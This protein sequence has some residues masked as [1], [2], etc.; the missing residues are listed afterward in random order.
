[1]TCRVAFEYPGASGGVEPLAGWNPNK[2]RQDTRA[3][4]MVALPVNLIMGE[5]THPYFERNQR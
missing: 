4:A 2:D 5:S 1:M 3:M